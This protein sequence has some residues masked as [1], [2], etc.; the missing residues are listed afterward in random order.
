MFGNI[1]TTS[2]RFLPFNLTFLTYRCGTLSI[3]CCFVID[4][5]E[6]GRNPVQMNAV[7]AAASLSVLLMISCSLENSR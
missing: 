7:I 4:M 3:N 5:T 2:C 1:I 6:T